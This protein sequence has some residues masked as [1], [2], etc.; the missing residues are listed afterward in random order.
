M[1]KLTKTTERLKRL[2]AKKTRRAL[3]SQ[4]KATNYRRRRHMYLKA[5]KRKQEEAL[6]EKALKDSQQ[7]S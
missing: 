2:Q 6:L 7:T 5:I 1:R 4:E 3:R